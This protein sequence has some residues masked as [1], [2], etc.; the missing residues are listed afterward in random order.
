MG[1]GSVRS[2]H[3]VRVAQCREDTYRYCLLTDSEMARTNDL[4][5][6]YAVSYLFLDAPDD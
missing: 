4:L 6:C 5:R 2:E 3:S 1:V